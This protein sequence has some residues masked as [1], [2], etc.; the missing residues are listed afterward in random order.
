MQGQLHTPTDGW[1]T[2]RAAKSAMYCELTL[3]YTAMGH[4]QRLP[5]HGSPPVTATQSES[6]VQD[7]S[8]SEAGI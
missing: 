3:A 7:W 2:L 1:A 8:R 6:D 4:L 5:L